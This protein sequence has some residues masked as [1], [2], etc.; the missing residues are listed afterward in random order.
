MTLSQVIPSKLALGI[1]TLFQDPGVIGTSTSHSPVPV[2]LLIG[3][4]FNM[5][6]LSAGTQTST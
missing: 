5:R 1:S 4:T 3:V 6:A 2:P